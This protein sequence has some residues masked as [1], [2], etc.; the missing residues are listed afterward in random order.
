MSR[1]EPEN[2]NKEK[3]PVAG[4]T[5]QTVS[6]TKAVNSATP[7]MAQ[8]LS[9]K[10][11]HQEYLLF[12]RMG[13]FYELFF[14]DAVTA[15]AALD[16]TLT[17]R[18][19]HLGEPVSMC[20]VPYH[21]AEGYL[22]KLIRAG[23]KVAICEQTENPEEAKKRGTK[24]VVRREVVRLVTPGTLTEE[25]L[26]DARAHNYLA[27]LGY[28]A[29]TN[30]LALSWLDMS[31]GDVQVMTAPE[32]VGT[33]Y[34]EDVAVN[35]LVAQFAALSV[36]ELLLPESLSEKIRTR[37]QSA[38]DMSGQVTLALMPEAQ[39]GSRTGEQTILEA[40]QVETLE[41]FGVWSRAQI[42]ACGMLITYLNL[43]QM[44]QMPRLKPPQLLSGGGIMRLDQATRRNLELISTLGGQRNGCL[45]DALDLTV[46]AAGGRLLTTR[47]SAPLTDLQA[48]LERQSSVAFFLEKDSLRNDVRDL[49]RRAPD[50]ARALGRLS[51]ER[52]GPRDL[53]ILKQGLEAGFGGFEL[54][55]KQ[56]EEIPEE[57]ASA[58]AIFDKA[59]ASDGP[60]L[61]A[62]HDL[63]ARALDDDL[64][65]LARDGGFVVTGYDAALDKERALRDESR[66]VIASLQ[67]RY[68]DETDIKALKI[69]YNAVLGYHVDVP[70]AHGEKLSLP[71]HNNIFI[72]R[73]TLASSVRFSTQEL[74]DLAGQISR[75]AE[76]ALGM[77]LDIYQR[78]VDEACALSTQISCAAD[79][80]ASADVASAHAELVQ[81]RHWVCPLLYDDDRFL[82]TGGRHP[83]VEQALEARSEGPFIANDCLLNDDEAHHLMLLTGPNMAGKSTYLRQ[84]ALI[85][86]LAQAG[87][88]VPASRAEIG[89][90]DQVFS[91]VGA[92][93]DLAQGRSTFMVEMVETA[94]ILN[95]ASARSLVIL[96]EIGRGTATF[97]GLSIAWAT[98]EN[99]HEVTKC[100]ALF[101]THY[102]ELTSLSKRLQGLTNATMRVKEYQGEVVFLHEVCAGAADRSYGIHVA[103]LAGL[104]EAVIARAREVLTH[105]EQNR[106]Q[107]NALSDEPS[108]L[109]PLP[110]FSASFKKKEKPDPVHHALDEVN[111]DLLSPR[112]AL[113]SLYLLKKI[114]EEK[115]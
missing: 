72:H 112:E 74:G 52:G 71:P 56:S 80:L 51:L 78:L 68:K 48:I 15:A 14:E 88:F 77:E 97:D 106:R 27:A 3:L 104:P 31:T 12:Y 111:P 69:K 60:S 17:H 91:R 34:D 110:L 20:G 5:A 45:L 26:L 67:A 54:L 66:R 84:N 19:Q 73:Q 92:A 39:A 95:Q 103:Q 96:D 29:E 11:Q 63:L 53:K 49:L 93:D 86:I 24:S 33:R 62:L 40:Y 32:P 55:H 65:L 7:M 9:I 101:A 8:F 94:A 2:I 75:A 41:G 42:A 83:V 100:R 37:F 43:T 107:D 99:L 89:L 59:E 10:E 79:G 44:G 82:I 23:F 47:L 28:T 109:T 36:R 18:G 102:H 50:M 114:R 35:F 61:R 6:A 90:I 64:P 38:A 113:E 108:A 87:F 58:F 30:G 57:L 115:K 1:T 21:A 98:V 81:A 105:L 22:H 4:E 25:G 16:I 85:A 13:D 46:S 76:R 70:P